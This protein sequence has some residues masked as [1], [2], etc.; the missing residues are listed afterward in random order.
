MHEVHSTGEGLTSDIKG[1]T[2][3]T[4]SGRS[5]NCEQSVVAALLVYGTSNT[6]SN[7]NIRHT[8]NRKLLLICILLLLHSLLFF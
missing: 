7:I 4:P 2:T 3:Q 5:A 6:V 8:D 1:E